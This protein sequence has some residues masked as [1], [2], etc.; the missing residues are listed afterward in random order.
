MK[1]TWPVKMDLSRFPHKLFKIKRWGSGYGSKAT[2]DEREEV[3][4]MADADIITSQI[5]NSKMHT[6]MLDLDVPAKLIRSTTA[7]H[8]H[9]Y[10]DVP[11]C[12]PRYK[13]LLE[14]LAL[15][16]VLEPAYVEHS[17]TKGFTA[18]RLPWVKKEERSSAH[19]DLGVS[20]DKEFERVMRESIEAMKGL[21]RVRRAVPE[22]RPITPDMKLEWGD[23]SRPSF[24][25]ER[26]YDSWVEPTPKSRR[27]TS[28]EAA[29]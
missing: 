15:A 17:K 10:I 24:E 29:K 25:F 8:S 22:A 20:L 13:L 6:I 3:S 9:L 12:W 27:K 23:V 4:S 18:L 2:P 16:G 5:E 28:K 21:D 11:V 26:L 7:G 19:P 1:D 14:A